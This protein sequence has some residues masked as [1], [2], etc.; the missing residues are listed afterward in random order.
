MRICTI[1]ARGGSKGIPGKNIRPLMGKPL[2]GHSIRQALDSGL[3]QIVAISSDSE[4]ILEAAAA[5]GPVHLIRRPAELA[6][7]KADK[8]PVMR[9]AVDTVERETG[10]EFQTMVDLD[11]TSPLRRLSDI[12][13]CIEMIERDG[14]GNILTVMPARRSPY[15]NQLEQDA[16]G[17]WG[18]SKPLKQTVTGR[19]SAPASFDMNASIYAWSRASFMAGP[20]LYAA[21]TAVHVMPLEHSWD[22]DEPIDFEVAAFLMKRNAAFE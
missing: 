21:D 10:F 14:H 4:A 8:T 12:Q 2:I 3:F 1:C 20:E 11:A 13:A 9:H 22:I 18:L 17:R 19:Q 16:N 7:D 6:S 5:E 15:F